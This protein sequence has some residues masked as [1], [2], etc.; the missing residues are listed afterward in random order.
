M[1]QD[2]LLPA[3]FRESGREFG[4]ASLA[5]I[6]AAL[7]ALRNLLRLAEALQ[8]LLAANPWLSGQLR[9]DR[10]DLLVGVLLWKT[11][12]RDSSFLSRPARHAAVLRSCYWACRASG[13]A[14]LCIPADEP[15]AAR[16]FRK[17]RS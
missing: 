10:Q 16:H 7:L 4:T 15:N 8:T 17:P 9:R 2:D 11:K 3:C 1:T 14:V 12:Y 13:A 6:A 5:D